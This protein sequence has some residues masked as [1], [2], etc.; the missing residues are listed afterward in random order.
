MVKL[1]E[2]RRDHAGR[3]LNLAQ[4]P[5]QMRRENSALQLRTA[6][7]T[8]LT[9]LPVRKTHVDLK[10]RRQTHVDQTGRVGPPHHWNSGRGVSALAA[11]Q[12]GWAVT[13]CDRWGWHKRHMSRCDT[14]PPRSDLLFLFFNLLPV[15]LG[16]YRTGHQNL[17]KTPSAAQAGIVGASRIARSSSP[18]L[19][20]SITDQAKFLVQLSLLGTKCVGKGIHGRTRSTPACLRYN[21]VSALFVS[22]QVG[23]GVCYD[24]WA[25]APRVAQRT[26]KTVPANVGYEP[27][28]MPRL[29]LFK[30]EAKGGTGPSSYSRPRS[31]IVSPHLLVKPGSTDLTVLPIHLST[32]HSLASACGFLFFNTLVPSLLGR[33]TARRLQCPVAKLIY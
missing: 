15:G 20:K 3:G 9:A 6:A 26:C 5:Q 23:N 21:G 30:K 27:R 18:P 7:L 25:A 29:D 33:N 14:S 1:Q 32:F 2:V 13:C 11:R 17:A 19:R 31:L 10:H 24:D 8:G 28:T 16:R 12:S 22:V 4:A